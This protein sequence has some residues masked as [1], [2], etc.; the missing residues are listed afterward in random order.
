MIFINDR[1]IVRSAIVISFDRPARGRE[2]T[3][4]SFQGVFLLQRLAKTMVVL[5]EFYKHYQ[6]FCTHIK[7]CDG[8][9]CA[10]W[11]LQQHF[12]FRK[13]LSILTR[14]PPQPCN[15]FLVGNVVV[16]IY[17]KFLLMLRIYRWRLWEFCTK[18]YTD[19]LR[20]L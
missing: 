6:P 17:A 12:Y 11:D 16:N 13:C 10:F 19:F 14:A 8:S 3:V 18:I 4:C 5:T 7:T 20:I 2:I 1:Y 9:Q 15:L